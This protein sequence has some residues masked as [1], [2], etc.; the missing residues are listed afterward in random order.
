MLSLS[1]WA[2]SDA[3]ILFE[4]TVIV[5]NARTKLPPNNRIKKVILKK[6]SLFTDCVMMK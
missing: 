3:Y 4:G 5:T 2:E 6:C 1:L